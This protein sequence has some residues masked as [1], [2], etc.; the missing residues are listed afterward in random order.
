MVG[1]EIAAELAVLLFGGSGVLIG[2][3]DLVVVAVGGVLVL[4]VGGPVG[5]VGLMIGHGR[6]FGVCQE[7]ARYEL[8]IDDLRAVVQRK[9][10]EIWYIVDFEIK[11]KA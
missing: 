5:L 2:R 7:H 8:D 10:I 4:A 9:L 1:L 6:V 3:E 11:W